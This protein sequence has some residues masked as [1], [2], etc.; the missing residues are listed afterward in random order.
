MQNITKKN[1]NNSGI[2]CIINTS[3]NKRYI[4]SS[5]NLYTRLMKHRA[6]LRHSKH[7]NRKIQNS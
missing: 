5:V 6:L 7:D 3:N 4:G 1:L 2:Y